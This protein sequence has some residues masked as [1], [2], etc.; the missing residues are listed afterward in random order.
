MI[1]LV[2]E[3]NSQKF[4]MFLDFSYNFLIFIYYESIYD[5]KIF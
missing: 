2:L 5:N 3:I 4:K 1:N